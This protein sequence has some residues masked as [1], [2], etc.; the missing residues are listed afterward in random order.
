[1]NTTPSIQLRLA[2]AG[3]EDFLLRLY[4]T[5]RAAEVAAWGWPEAQ[6]T[7]FLQMQFRA[8]R[9][10]SAYP[11]AT[12]QI[13]LWEGE[14]VGH[15]LIARPEGEIRLVDVALLPAHQRL[16]IGT[17]LLQD[18]QRTAQTERLPIR[19]RVAYDNPARF[20]YA[21]HGFIQL[22]DRGSHW[23]MEWPNA[24]QDPMKEEHG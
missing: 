23:L 14:A 12:E 19:L 18:L 4:S 20:W 15:W 11:N 17:T 3:D 8:Q 24:N 22:E 7:A 21:R 16:G 2:E 5:T 6:R 10:H 1:M 9:G 13:V